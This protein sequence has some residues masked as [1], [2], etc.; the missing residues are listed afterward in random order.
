MRLLHVEVAVF[1]TKRDV[2]HYEKME[3]DIKLGISYEKRIPMIANIDF[4]L[5]FDYTRTVA[6]S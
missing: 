2:L 3:K 1:S 6:L 4:L 5:G